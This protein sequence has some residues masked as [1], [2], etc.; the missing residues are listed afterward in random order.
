MNPSKPFVIPKLEIVKPLKSQVKEGYVS[1][2]HGDDLG[3]IVF[4]E[5]RRV[6]NI[7]IDDLVP[8]ENS[9]RSSHD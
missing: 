6:G 8:I 1:G 4:C 9:R 7:I 2:I 5:G 3:D